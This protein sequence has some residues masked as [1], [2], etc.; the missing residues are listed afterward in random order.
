MSLAQWTRTASAGA[1]TAIVACSGAT[2]PAQDAAVGAYGLM[3]VNGQRLPYT[4][5]TTSLSRLEMTAGTLSLN[6]DQRY[7][8]VF[9]TRLTPAGEAPQPHVDTSSGT[10][11]RNG[12]SLLFRSSNGTSWVGTYDGHAVT[13]VDNGLTLLYQR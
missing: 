6:E 2:G 5:R 11:V 4:L 3:A 1:I 13:S 7:R 10:Y 12:T 9:N 8:I